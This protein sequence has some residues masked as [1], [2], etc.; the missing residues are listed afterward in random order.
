MRRAAEQQKHDQSRMPI[1]A[2]S[3]M[4]GL[5]DGEGSQRS[6]SENYDSFIL[7]VISFDSPPVTCSRQAEPNNDWSQQEAANIQAPVIDNMTQSSESSQQNVTT[8]SLGSAAIS[9]TSLSYGYGV[10]K[11]PK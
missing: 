6:S 3:E 4:P 2:A 1:D 7:Q 11:I 8:T 10:F 5:Q 9:V